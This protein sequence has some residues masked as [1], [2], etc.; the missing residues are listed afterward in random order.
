MVHMELL[1]HYITSTS[2]YPLGYEVMKEIIMAIGLQEPYV[3]H[4]VLALSAHHISVT[5]P[6]QRPS[7]RDLAI[8]LQTR[9]LSLFNSVDMGLLGDSVQKRVPVF[10]F[11]SVVGFHAL[12]DFLTYR[13]RDFQH[14]FACFLAYLRLHR[15][16]GT[17]MAG[18]WDK[19]QATELGV[20]EVVMPRMFELDAEGW[21]CDD[22][23]EKFTSLGLED[24]EVE[25]AQR[26]ID[27]VQWVFDARPKVESRAYVLCAW[28]PMLPK[29]F[30]E[31]L[32][33][34]RPE[35]LAVLAYYFLAMHY[36][37]E[38]WMLGEAGQHLLTLLAGHFR[39]GEWY[40]WVEP[41]YRALQESLAA[42]ACDNQ[43][44]PDATMT[45]AVNLSSHPEPGPA[46]N[47]EQARSDVVRIHNYHTTSFRSNTQ[48]P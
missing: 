15:G 36:C 25:A 16:I 26:A 31:M 20:L 23:R 30:V 1:H 12:C 29:P 2:L 44:M 7:Y 5:Q 21:E 42:D 35:A 46:N 8:Q 34:G 17:V 6:E 32:E 48:R 3:M 47:S 14:A 38:V 24:E 9:A 11:S 4:S 13:D 41:P 28:V 18:Y 45:D 39:G 43:F 10:I 40:A 37:R 27:M 19:L 33:E 22:I